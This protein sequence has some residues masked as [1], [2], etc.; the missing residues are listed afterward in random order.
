MK[1]TCI[2]ND[3]IVLFWPFCSEVLPSWWLL[4]GPINLLLG[5]L[6]PSYSALPYMFSPLC[7]YWWPTVPWNLFPFAVNSYLVSQ[8]FNPICSFSCFFSKF[9]GLCWWVLIR[10]LCWC[11][12][13]GVTNSK[14]LSLF[15]W[16][17]CHF[18]SEA[19]CVCSGSSLEQSTCSLLCWGMYLYFS[20]YFVRHLTC[21]GKF[22]DVFGNIFVKCAGFF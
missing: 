5:Q 20:S 14:Q 22:V 15:W 19:K 16:P 18:L 6:A 8:I 11:F 9:H 1:T 4:C 13:C 10:C 21:W 2:S 3:W 12:G 7:W 17:V